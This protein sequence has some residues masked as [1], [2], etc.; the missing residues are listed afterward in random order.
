MTTSL[1]TLALTGKSGTVY[2][3]AVYPINTELPKSGGVYVFTKRNQS[4]Q[5]YTHTVIYIG[6]T[7][8][9]LARHYNHHKD[10]CIDKNGATHICL[11]IEGSEKRRKE[12]EVDLIKAY[13]PPCNEVHT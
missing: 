3:F 5:S 1:A 10:D 11:L 4:N 7:Q 2:T 13:N 12:I 9:F 6:M 8:E